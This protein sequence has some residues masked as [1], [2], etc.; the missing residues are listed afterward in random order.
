MIDK[1]YDVLSIRE[2]FPS[3]Q[4]PSSSTWVYNISYGL[5]Q[6][7][8]RPIVLSPTAIVPSWLK[9]LIELNHTW[10]T[11]PSIKVDSYKSIDIIRPVF[12][13]FPNKFLFPYNI[14]SLTNCITRYGAQFN[15]RLLHAHFGHAGV[16][17]L[18]LKRK[19]EIPLITSFYGF[20]LGGDKDRLKPYYKSLSFSG[21]LFLAL[22]NDM[23]N[24]LIDLG[25]PS[26]KI[27]IHKLGIDL[28]NFIPLNITNNKDKFVFLTVATFS[29]R[30]GIHYT[31]QAFKAFK[32]QVKIGGCELRIIGDGPYREKLY[33]YAR[34]E[35]DIVFINN[36]TAENPRDLIKCEMQMCDVFMLNSITL[37]NSDKEGTPI[38][39]MEAQA[40]GKPCISSYHAGISEVV[41][42][43]ETGFLCSERSVSKI[44]D[45]MLTLYSNPEMRKK[46]GNNARQHITQNYNNARQILLLKEIY[47]ELLK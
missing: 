12:S 37:Q 4:N 30:K 9:Y 19:K 41:I 47:N 24:D 27:L 14:N 31:I 17:A 11:P 6:I 10:K 25:F 46:F 28:D 15:V 26:N 16:S 21:D 7:G 45:A 44:S 8:I 18:R 2:Y 32:E 33:E 38:V 29:E 35:K 36:H 40:C 20:D 34:G 3:D 42:D 1:H 43:G 22:S 13:I 23:A 5:Q 39:L